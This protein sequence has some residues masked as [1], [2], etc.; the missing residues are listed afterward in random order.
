MSIRVE[1]L[2]KQLT[3]AGTWVDTMKIFDGNREAAV[4]LGSL[5]GLLPRDAGSVTVSA[6]ARY[7]YNVVG[8]SGIPIGVEYQLAGSRAYC[9]LPPLSETRTGTIAPKGSSASDVRGIVMKQEEVGGVYAP[10]PGVRIAYTAGL[11]SG[12]L[13]TDVNGRYFLE[14][15]DEGDTV[16]LTA[17][18]KHSYVCAPQQQALVATLALVQANTILYTSDNVSMRQL[19]LRDGK[20]NEL[21]SWERENIGDTSYYHLPCTQNGVAQLSVACDFPAGVSGSIF[22]W[23]DAA[24]SGVIGAGKVAAAVTPAARFGGA[25]PAGAPQLEVDIS[26]AGHRVVT[27]A[28][29]GENSLKYTL[30]LDKNLD[31]FDIVNE[32]MGN[33]LRVV[34]A[35]PE[36]NSTGLE[37]TSCTWWHKRESGEWFIGEEKQLH[38]T[39][40]SIRDK[41]TEKDSMY[42]VLTLPDGSLISTCPD[43]NLIEAAN[44][45]GESGSDEGDGKGSASKKS[46][47]MA[48]YPN[49]VP[50]GGTIKL[51]QV[52][53][54]DGEDEDNRYLK[55]SLYDTQ[56]RLI[57]RGDASPLYEGQGLIM[58]HTSGIYHL[59]LESKTGKRW[60]VKIAVGD[61]K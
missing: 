26:R 59:L 42:L 41:F 34:N 8:I 50:S 55:Y 22:L 38:Y 5:Q 32:H 31:F 30:V 47:K 43:A 4:I 17:P 57:L 45:G 58:P 61:K 52:N 20:G 23:E 6:T 56:G 33:L 44:D 46:L 27:I 60:V 2:P 9:Y 51:K 25:K 39:A 7:Q 13:T 16:T 53:L 10:W 19:A 49:P 21:V 3:I 35:N 29:N 14:G 54:F 1:V 12:V 48:V 15:L 40:A 37:F 24:A 11:R 36:T 28:L 18:P